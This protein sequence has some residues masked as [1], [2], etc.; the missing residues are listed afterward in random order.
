MSSCFDCGSPVT[1]VDRFCGNC[2]LALQ[3]A[4]GAGGGAA[5]S[6]TPLAQEGGAGEPSRSREPESSGYDDEQFQ[7]T[8]I[9]PSHGGQAAAAAR[10]SEPVEP[11]DAP[12]ASAPA[13]SQGLST[14]GSTELSSAVA[15]DVEITADTSDEPPTG[16]VT[17][18]EPPADESVPEWEPK[19]QNTGGAPSA[20]VRDRRTG[21]LPSRPMAFTGRTGGSSSAGRR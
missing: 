7:P 18:G 11:T 6:S 16:A 14:A 4:P 3:S 20:G 21:D 19:P 2:G 12:E 15:E 1:P 17:G 9:E 10:A 8:I 5:P 13:D